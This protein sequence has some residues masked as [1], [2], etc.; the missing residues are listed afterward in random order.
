[1]EKLL[2][3]EGVSVNEAF[4]KATVILQGKISRI[5]RPEP[6]E[7]L[8]FD[9]SG[10]ALLLGITQSESDDL[11]KRCLGEDGLIDEERFVEECEKIFSM[12]K[13]NNSSA[14]SNFSTLMMPDGTMSVR[15]YCTQ[16]GYNYNSVYVRIQKQIEETGE[17][18]IDKA[19]SDYVLDGQENPVNYKFEYNNILYRH[20]ALEM[21]LDFDKI[22]YRMRKYRIDL[23]RAMEMEIV[24]QVP[25]SMEFV[26]ST[27]NNMI[28]SLSDEEIRKN[29]IKFK[30]LANTGEKKCMND[31]FE[32]IRN[33][34]QV[35]KYINLY[36]IIE[37]RVLQSEEEKESLARAMGITDY[38]RFKEFVKVNY[39]GNPG[40]LIAPVK[41]VEKS[42]PP[43][44]NEGGR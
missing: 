9:S 43:I 25:D 16:H 39:E 15:Q 34:T 8:E 26:S 14:K 38:E 4:E 35:V 24:N 32:K 7:Y 40:Y 22:L 1:M 11:R 18:N 17:Y 33:M 20:T 10:L 21:G 42:V 30:E 29:F 44:P 2:K 3:D 13:V 19:I 6:S 5:I 28:A 37:N 12:T 41:R 27:I 36:R 31:V 23:K